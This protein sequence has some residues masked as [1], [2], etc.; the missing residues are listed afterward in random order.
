VALGEAD[1][2]FDAAAMQMHELLAGSTQLERVF[3]ELASE[4]GIHDES[5]EVVDEPSVMAAVDDHAAD[6]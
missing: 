5:T 4:M 3:A 6:F 1:A 2:Q